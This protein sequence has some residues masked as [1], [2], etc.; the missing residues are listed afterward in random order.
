MFILEH[1]IHRAY[2]GKRSHAAPMFE[3]QRLYLTRFGE[4][5]E[6]RYPLKVLKLLPSSRFASTSPLYYVLLRA[7]RDGR[8]AS[9]ES[10]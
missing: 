3:D 2:L 8:E 4:L 7:L 5:R 10:S 6:G 9:F 1:R